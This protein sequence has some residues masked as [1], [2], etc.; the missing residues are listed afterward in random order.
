M[1]YSILDIKSKTFGPLTEFRTDQEAIRSFLI[2][3]QN[4]PKD[5]LLSQFPIDFSI[6]R[7]GDY[8]KLTGLL[9]QDVAPYQLCTGLEVLQMLKD[10]SSEVAVCANLDVS[11]DVAFK[12]TEEEVNV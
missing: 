2:C 5:S 7:I 11:D 6:F 1:L 4:A 8:D 3:I 10:T 9:S 12:S